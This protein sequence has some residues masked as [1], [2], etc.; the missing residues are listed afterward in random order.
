MKSISEDLSHAE[1]ALV[2]SDVHANL[3]ALRAALALRLDNE[4]ILFA[5]DAIGYYAEPNECIDLLRNSGAICVRGNHEAYVIGDLIPN[6]A[7]AAKYRVDWTREQLRPNTLAWVRE[8]PH[9]V[10]IKATSLNIVLRHANPV[11]EETYLYPDTD[12]GQYSQP[13]G[14][15][16]I[17]G[18]THHPML[19]DAGA[20]KVL[21]PGSVGQPRDRKPKPSLARVGL[22]TGYVEFL[23]AEYDVQ[24]YQ[25]RLRSDGWPMDTIDMLSKH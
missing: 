18:H 6:P 5:G 4:P 2:I 20:G 7:N 23:R 16:L 25:A 10:N 8:L 17:V 1:T 19:R 9:T 12:L 21:N 24:A 15:L 3:P 14:Q 11:D 13:E 22:V